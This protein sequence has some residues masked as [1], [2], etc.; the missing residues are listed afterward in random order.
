MAGKTRGNNPETPNSM[1]LRRTLILAI[2]CGIVAFS[3]LGLRLLKLQILDHDFYET[4]AVEGQLRD[5]TVT[6]ERGTIYDTNMKILAMSASV[7][8]VYISP[9]EIDKYD[10]DEKK[11]ITH[12]FIADKLAEILD[13]KSAD[14]LEKMGKSKTW[15]QTLALKVEPEVSDAVRDFKT[16]YDLVGVRLEDTSKRYYPYSTLAA[17]VIGFVGNDD[18]GLAGIEAKYDDVLTG[19]NGRKVRLANAVGTEMLLEDY[20]Y[21]YDSKDGEG[22]VLTL[23]STIQYYME[24]HLE[25]A[26]LDYDVKNGAA[27]IAMDV[28]TGAILGMVSLGNFDLNDY[29]TV[30]S[31]VQQ[32]IDAEQDEEAKAKLLFDAQQLQWRNKAISDTYEPGSTF[33]I[34]TL[35]MA[36]NEGVVSPEDSFYCGGSIDVTG[37]DDPVKCWKRQ[38]HGSQTL[39]QAL[40][41]S[42][43]VAFVKIGLQVGAKKFYEYCENFGFFKASEDGSEYLHGKTGIDLLG[44]GSSI[45]WPHDYF[46]NDL[47]KS[48][49][50]AAS[51]GQ[52]FNIT[53]I[54]LITAVSA[55]C[56]GGYLMEPYLIKSTLDS[57]GNAISTTEP[58]VVR[59]VVSEETSATVCGMLEQVVCDKKEGTGK[60]AYVAG[61]RIGGKT[62]TSEKVSKQVETGDDEYIVSFIGVAPMDD[63]KIA[64][65]TLLDNPSSSCGVLVGGGQMCAPTVGKMMAD[66]LPYMGYEP[67]Y[68]DDDQKQ[69]DRSVPDIAG[70]SLADAQAAV[71]KAGF[72]YRVIGTG[73]T[74]TDQLPAANSVIAANS[75]VIIYCDEKPS[76]S[77]E[78]VPDLT[79]MSYSVAR[80]QLGSIA[81]FVRTSGAI[82]DSGSLVVTNQSVKAGTQVEHGTV[83]N[84]TIIDLANQGRF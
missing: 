14:I 17:Q 62:G 49:L 23:D 56:N 18:D 8:N 71:T 46:T 51:F 68:N 78:T 45:W 69:I 82:S 22:L 30:S 27:A 39:T 64:I 40:Q 53:P 55:C 13:I 35:A 57:E 12:S 80:Q 67:Q 84:V 63:P 38:G 33:K 60:N 73:G 21:Y 3:V 59:Q 72:T 36:L 42:C 15:Y 2:V 74:V 52:T 58:K 43:N 25:Q 28:D 41:H 10:V 29:Q 24:K 81:L 6:A 50:A 83:I 34:I 70:M 4:A 5:T 7:Y 66:I 32:K 11:G 65:L 76:T 75:Q 16:E 1:M 54:Q 48:S 19:I 20:E 9:V 44:E 61:Y 37:R 79:G 31:E 26:V 47:N 77:L